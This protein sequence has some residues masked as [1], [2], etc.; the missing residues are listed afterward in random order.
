MLPSGTGVQT[1]T[2]FGALGDLPVAGDFS[3]L[4][5]SDFALWRASLASWLVHPSNGSSNVTM[6]LGVAENEP[7]YSIP[8]ITSHYIFPSIARDPQ[9]SAFMSYAEAGAPTACGAQ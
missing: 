3:G 8:P 4:G 5:K 9:E 6:A 1:Q 2:Q 7:V